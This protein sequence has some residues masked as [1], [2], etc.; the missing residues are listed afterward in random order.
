MKNRITNP[1][2]APASVSKQKKV[3]VIGSGFHK[4]ISSENSILSDWNLL[5]KSLDS[6]IIS[7]G[8]QTL[9]FEE[10]IVR[11]TTA[12][13]IKKRTASELEKVKLIEITKKIDSAQRKIPLEEILAKYSYL[14]DPENVS[15]IISL[16]FDTTL[17][18]LCLMHAQNLGI[19][20][21]TAKKKIHFKSEKIDV[22]SYDIEFLNGNII[23]FWYPH[24]SIKS[25]NSMTLG[26][27]SY[28][29]RMADVEELRKLSKSKKHVVSWYHQF[30]HNPVILIGTSLSSLEWDLWFAI[31]NR[32]RNFAKKSNKEFRTDISMSSISISEKRT[33]NFW[34]NKPSDSKSYWSSIQKMIQSNTNS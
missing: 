8:N 14:F 25:A 34:I 6:K 10:I 20:I 4:E 27:R 22:R 13:I 12:D 30:T 28:Y 2:P 1:L 18:S 24:G 26:V 9:V 32:E 33:T 15:D 21:K 19:K 17:E 16:N 5:L 7:E 29:K 11:K 3:L 31:V 23:R